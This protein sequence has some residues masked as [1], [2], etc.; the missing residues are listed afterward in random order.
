MILDEVLNEAYLGKNKE[1]KHMEDLIEKIRNKY[2]EKGTI[3]HGFDTMFKGIESSTEW[4]ELRQAFEDTFGFYSVSLLLDTDT[5]LP[6]AYTFPM[7]I[8][9]DANVRAPFALSIKGKGIKYDKK[10]KFCTIIYITAPLLFSKKLTSAEVLA[11]LLHEV[12]H[13]F[14]TAVLP[15]FL[16]I[17]IL[18]TIV[19]TSEILSGRVA[20]ANP[21]HILT[22]LLA[23]TT[24][25]RMLDNAI[26]NMIQKSPGLLFI[27]HILTGFINFIPHI[28]DILFKIIHPVL[29][30]QQIP[31]IMAT[32]LL[33]PVLVAQ[34]LVFANV[35][36]YPAETFSDSF[37]TLLGYGP[38]LQSALIKMEYQ[39]IDDGVDTN[40]DFSRMPIVGH[41]IGINEYIYDH[42]MSL[43]NGHPNFNARLKT[44]INLL[45]KDL[46][47]PRIDKKT[48][49]QVKN[50]LKKLNK[51][52]DEFNK[53]S[54]S[55]KEMYSDDNYAHQTRAA[56]EKITEFVYGRHAP[57]IRSKLADIFY[58]GASSIHKSFERLRRNQ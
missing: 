3:L 8:T 56:M 30:M 2:G 37:A 31:S 11:V 1:L 57:D 45:E 26:T 41:W 51:L 22:T 40:K 16:G 20:G 18:R 10:Q 4:Q 15:G 49:Y 25:T 23:L 53:L 24:P 12:G 36:S 58:G 28:F 7:S 38:E 42:F 39:V 55:D 17:P 32:I 44:S 27:K 14:D 5:E 46:E 21:S 19:T 9:P 13:N 47:D 34:S 50:D 54:D 6:N 33:S 35:F 52:Y 43:T 48:K 29:K